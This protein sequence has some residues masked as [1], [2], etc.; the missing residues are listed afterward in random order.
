MID[1]VNKFREI[2]LEIE[3]DKQ[4]NFDLVALI[5]PEDNFG[6]LDLVL[7]ANWIS[8]NEK[9]FLDY[10]YPKISKKLGLLE[11][12][13]FSGVVILNPSGEFMQ[14]YKNAIGPIVKDQEYT[15]SR[16]ANIDVRYAHL[17]ALQN[18]SFAH[19]HH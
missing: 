3:L 5:E 18:N 14:W 4:Q 7:S 10:L 9:H 12:L 2:L 13:K 15:N 8:E 1:I 16:I 6:K 17:F 19:V 11:L